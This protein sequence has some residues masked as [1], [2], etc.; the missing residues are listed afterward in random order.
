MSERPEADSVAPAVQQR[1]PSG[2]IIPIQALTDRLGPGTAVSIG[3]L[4]ILIAGSVVS[5]YFL[6]LRNIT[7]V[8]LQSAML[9][10]APSVNCTNS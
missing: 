7:N 3:F 1:R 6:T 9:G 5:P 2:P 8:L 4:L 10:V